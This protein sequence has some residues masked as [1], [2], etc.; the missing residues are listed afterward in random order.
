MKKILLS[1]AVVASGATAQEAPVCPDQPSTPSMKVHRDMIRCDPT[2]IRLGPPTMTKSAATITFTNRPVN[3]PHNDETFDL[4]WDLITVSVTFKYTQGA[5]RIDVIPPV[6]YI[7][8][9][10]R[11]ELEENT[12]G[13]I[14]IIPYVGF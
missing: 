3:G 11:L 4:T 8:I 10:D 6:G 13:E 9:P 14:Q 1:L 7:A 12:S 5:D 2:V